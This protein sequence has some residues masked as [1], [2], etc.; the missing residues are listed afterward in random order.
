MKAGVYQIRNLKNNKLYIGSAAAGFRDRWS[1]HLKQ[2]RNSQ[3]HSVHLQRAWNKYTEEVFIFEVL[4]ECSPE[5]CLDREQYYLDTLLF[6]NCNDKRFNQLGYNICRVAGSTRGIKLSLSERQLDIRRDQ[7]RRL[8]KLNSK[9]SVDIA[10]AILDDLF[11]HHTPV[12]DVIIKYNI[13][14]SS[15]GDIKNNRTWKEIDRSIYNGLSAPR[16]KLTNVTKKKMSLAKCGEGSYCAKLTEPQ[17][18]KIK[19]MIT[20][21]LNNH[22]I[23]VFF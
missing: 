14:K 3:H 23:A 7:G 10:K 6:A 4:E 11:I 13:S 22:E 8:G 9:L 12:R 15:I 18:T 5:Q 17:V 19:T 20:R 2:L 21:G 1:L 16:A